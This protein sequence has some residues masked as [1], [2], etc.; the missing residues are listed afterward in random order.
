V[1]SMCRLLGWVSDTPRA[2]A[3][4]LT[5]AELAEFTELSR[6][7]ADG[8][9]IAWYDGDGAI[10][11]RRSEGAAYRDE[12]YAKAVTEI[13][14][15]G[16]VLHLRWATPGI[17]VQ[18]GN[19][20]P[21]VR[22]GYAFAHNGSIWPRDGLLDLID[23]VPDLVGDTDSELYL[24]ALLQRA[25]KLGF[26]DGLRETIT[27]ITAELTPSSLNALLL[28]D[29]ALTVLC[30][31]VGDAG[32]PAD[33]GPD[34][35]PEKLP[36]YYDLRLRHIGDARLVASS[37]WG[38]AGGWEQVEN[39]TALILPVGGGAARSVPIGGYP[40]AAAARATKKRFSGEL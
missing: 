7:H 34:A 19:T 35:A 36:G 9:G 33:A 23:T 22:D 11:T 18:P 2:L 5:T 4:L 6:H 24:L 26:D 16:A 1:Y 39:G 40:E 20:H 13:A 27:D 32:C 12:A 38:D 15:T 25:A 29:G 30:C 17:P 21:F 28:G 14:S 37:G 8:W 31:N 3:D 10:Q